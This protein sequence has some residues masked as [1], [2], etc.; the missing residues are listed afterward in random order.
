MYAK[1]D[2]VKQDIRKGAQWF[3]KAANQGDREAEYN[4][5]V[6]F[7]KHVTDFQ[8]AAAWYREA[9][10]RG[11][12]R[13]QCRLGQMYMEGMGV[14]RNPDEASKWFGMAAQ[15]G[16]GAT[17]DQRE[18]AKPEYSADERDLA[19]GRKPVISTKA[20]KQPPIPKITT[21]NGKVYKNVAV[22]RVQ[23]DGITVEFEPDEGGFGAAKLR[24]EDLSE[25]L[26]Q[27]FGYDAQ[28]AA[29]Y[30]AEQSRLAPEGAEELR[31]AAEQGNAEAQYS[32]GVSY[33]TGKGVPRDAA[34]AANWY[35]KAAQ[36]GYPPAQHNLSL[37]Y[38]SGEGVNRDLVEAASVVCHNSLV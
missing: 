21:R 11:F 37:L 38:I 34:E 19:N 32:L 4:L 9:A 29:A 7:E 1:G 23:H 17:S 36:N 30:E 24:L 27:S 26:Q 18:A 8:R 15:Q 35:R 12:A 5:G 6:Y 28:K 31:E 13:A 10:E 20:P 22:G 2:G 33:S 14:N 16:L 25:E 3:R